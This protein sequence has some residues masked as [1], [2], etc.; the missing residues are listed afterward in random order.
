[1]K[2]TSSKGKPG[3]DKSQDQATS[4]NSEHSR[5]VLSLQNP[6]IT[7]LLPHESLY[8]NIHIFRSTIASTI[9]QKLAN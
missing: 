1:M 3:T 4:I 7:K 8:N 5:I 6:A 9:V 2:F